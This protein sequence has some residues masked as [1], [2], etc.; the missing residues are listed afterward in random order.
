MTKLWKSI[1]SINEIKDKVHRMVE[2]RY[3]FPEDR[4]RPWSKQYWTTTVPQA[5]NEFACCYEDGLV[6]PIIRAYRQM[7]MVGYANQLALE[8]LYTID[9]G[10]KRKI[11]P[12]GV[13]TAAIVSGTYD[14]MQ[15]NDKTL[16]WTQGSLLKRLGVCPKHISERYL[17]QN[18][19]D[20]TDPRYGKYIFKVRADEEDEN[21]Y[22]QYY[23]GTE[24]RK[25]FV[26]LA[27]FA[28]ALLV[29]R[30][31]DGRHATAKTFLEQWVDKFDHP[32]EMIHDIIRIKPHTDI[33]LGWEH[34][35]RLEEEL[36]REEE[37]VK[38]YRGWK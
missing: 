20:A 3:V 7:Y 23:T 4:L 18:L 14:A 27:V 35:E 10:P 36:G 13:V 9:E 15:N 19:A 5:R 33:S 28:R 17:R 12:W 32:E 6:P 26:K 16:L 2:E 34:I 38:I 22:W 29:A 21:S 37:V 31:V 25:V 8:R 11:E 1:H 24:G 30:A